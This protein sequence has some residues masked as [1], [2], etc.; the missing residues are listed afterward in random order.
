MVCDIIQNLH[1][2]YNNSLNLSSF[3]TSTLLFNLSATASKNSV[4]VT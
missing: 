2:I 1:H 3:Y 4:V